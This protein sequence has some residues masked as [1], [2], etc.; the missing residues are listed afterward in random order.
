MDQDTMIIKIRG[1]EI[2]K[3]SERLGKARDRSRRLADRLRTCQYNALD[4]QATVETK[5]RHIRSL[6][7][8]MDKQL[9]SLTTARSVMEAQKAVIKELQAEMATIRLVKPDEPQRV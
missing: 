4:L 8:Q 7:E 5:E 1:Q 3:L 6:L 9:T 2:A